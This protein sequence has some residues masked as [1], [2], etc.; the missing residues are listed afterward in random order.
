M[1][2]ILLEVPLQTKIGLKLKLA[3]PA[4]FQSDQEKFEDS[5]GEIKTCKSKKD[6]QYIGQ[7]KKTNNEVQITTQ[8]TKYR[9]TL[10]LLLLGI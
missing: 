6:R 5:K 3:T 7:Q 1:I 8:K 9:A 4:W 2:K 10:D